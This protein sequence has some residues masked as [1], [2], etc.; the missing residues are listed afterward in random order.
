VRDLLVVV[1]L[2]LCW[3]VVHSLAAQVRDLLVLVGVLQHRHLVHVSSFEENNLHEHSAF[4]F[5]RNCCVEYMMS[6]SFCPMYSLPSETQLSLS[7]DSFLISASDT[8]C[9]IS[10]VDC[11]V[12][13]LS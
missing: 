2:M 12:L 5:I 4:S 9:S 3:S 11:H 6:C 8:S 7:L 13:V 1:A 10:E